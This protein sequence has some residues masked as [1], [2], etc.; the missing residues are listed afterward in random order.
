MDIKIKTDLRRLH[1]YF[2]QLKYVGKE[3]VLNSVTYIKLYVLLIDVNCHINF[4]D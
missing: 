2:E 1:F 3:R 4:K